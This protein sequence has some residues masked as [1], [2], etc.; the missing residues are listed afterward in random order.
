MESRKNYERGTATRRYCGFGFSH[1]QCYHRWRWVSYLCHLLLLVIFQHIKLNWID[2]AIHNFNC[3]F[4]SCIFTFRSF[5]VSRSQ[6]FPPSSVNFVSYLISTTK[7]MVMTKATTVTTT[8]NLV[9]KNW[10]HFLLWR[11]L[12]F[13]FPSKSSHVLSLSLG[14]R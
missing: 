8:W 9:G 5:L 14:C 3:L 6:C 2:G 13:T 12:N 1:R 10:L 4:A 7:M 11:S